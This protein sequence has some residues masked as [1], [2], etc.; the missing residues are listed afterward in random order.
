MPIEMTEAQNVRL[1][2]VFSTD[3]AEV[4]GISFVYQSGDLKANVRIET[5]CHGIEKWGTF[6]PDTLL[7]IWK[8][9]NV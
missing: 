2:D 7:P 9:D 4:F 5:M 3:G 1:G 8:S 6:A